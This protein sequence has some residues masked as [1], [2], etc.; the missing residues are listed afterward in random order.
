[1]TTDRPDAPSY[2][3]RDAHKYARAALD[4]L[5]ALTHLARQ[6]DGLVDLGQARVV[7]GSLAAFAALLPQ[8]LV[9]VLR[10][11]GRWHGAEYI[12]ADSGIEFGGRPSTALATATNALWH[13][14]DSS[15]ELYEHLNTAAQALGNT[16]WIGPELPHSDVDPRESS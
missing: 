10:Q 12:G 11:L 3:P 7:L 14:S 8:A 15:V 16:R 2:D 1:M 6:P 4:A 5:Q 13:A 9:Q